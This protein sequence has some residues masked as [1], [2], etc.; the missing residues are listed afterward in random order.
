[1]PYLLRCALLLALLLSACTGEPDGTHENDADP[2]VATATTGS[3]DNLLLV[4]IDTVRADAFY[5]LGE[6]SADALSPW[7]ERALDFRRASSASSWTVPAFGSVLTGLW[8]SEHAAG[9]FDRV[10]AEM[11]VRPPPLPAADDV[12]F[13]PQAAGNQGMHTASF[14][15][16]TWTNYRVISLGLLRGFDEVARYQVAAQDLLAPTMIDDLMRSFAKH[17][18]EG[19]G[20]YLLHLMEAHDWHTRSEESLDAYLAGLDEQELA[21]LTAFDPSGTCRDRDSLICKRFL[22]YLSAIRAQ[23]E[24]VAT[25]LD[26][27]QAVNGLDDTAVVLFSDHGEEFSEHA[28]AAR[29]PARREGFARSYPYEYGHGGTMYEEILHVPLLVWHPAHDGAV[30]DEPVSLVDIAPSVA[31]WLDLDFAPQAWAGR[32]LEEALAPADDGEERVLYASG[33]AYGEQQVAVR[34]G[35]RKAVWF[36]ASSDSDFFDLATDPAERQPLASPD[37]ALQFDGFLVDYL[38]SIRA[39]EAPPGTFSDQQIKSLQAIGYLQN[40]DTD[41]TTAPR[42]APAQ[43][44]GQPDKPPAEAS[45]DP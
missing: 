20:L 38:D 4:C 37:W 9:R 10:V 17:R 18:A 34:R 45:A 16:S 25:L 28:G 40:A 41:G 13:L 44:Q 42:E 15:A 35:A 7:Q 11:S 21:V 43:E 3:V 19:G 39:P 23:R 22:V 12:E 30:V 2:G 27:L 36:A 29:T 33:I 6:S 5:S 32:H 1:M 8:P 24:A 14:S 26:R 31:R